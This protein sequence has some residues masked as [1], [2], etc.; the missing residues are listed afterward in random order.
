MANT[1]T[2]QRTLFFKVKKQVKVR[3]CGKKSWSLSRDPV[4]LNA[5]LFGVL[6]FTGYSHTY[7]PS[8]YLKFHH[9]FHKPM[10]PYNFVEVSGHNFE[11]SQ[12]WGF[13]IKGQCHEIFC[14]WFF[15]WISFPPAPEYPIRTVSNFFENS[16][17][18]SQVKVHLRC[19]RHRWQIAAG[20]NDNLPP[21]STTPAANFATSS[22]CA[23]DTGCQRYRRQICLRCQ[24]RRWQI[25]TGINDTGGKFAA[26]VVDT[27]G[28]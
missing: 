15:L 12:V 8:T 9:V 4:R 21:V 3:P 16:R 25:A 18:Y 26:G 22:P 17:R 7:S 20:I 24:R 23:V 1:I 6:H 11:S 10:W 14:F 2:H 27:G 28:K 13:S 19:Q 5:W